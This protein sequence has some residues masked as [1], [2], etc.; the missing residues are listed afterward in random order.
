MSLNSTNNRLLRILFTDFA[1]V[2]VIVLAGCGSTPASLPEI[3]TGARQGEHAAFFRLGPTQACLHQCAPEAI[4]FARGAMGATSS[5]FH[6][7]H[8]FEEVL[9]ESTSLGKAVLIPVNELLHELASLPAC[10][11][12]LVHSSDHLWLVVGEVEIDGDAKVQLVHGKEQGVLASQQEILD[13]GFRGAWKLERGSEPISMRVGSGE[14]EMDAVVKNLGVVELGVPTTATFI[15]KNAGNSPLVLVNAGSS[16]SC[17]MATLT[18]QTELDIGESYELVVTLKSNNA[19]SQRQH[20]IL[21]IHNSQDHTVVSKKLGIFACQKQSLPVLPSVVDFGAVLPGSSSVR[22]LR[23]REVDSIRFSLKDVDVAELRLT[24]EISHD[25]DQRG[26]AT[27]KIS[28]ILT[29]DHFAVPGKY[30]GTCVIA[31]SSLTHPQARIPIQ[32][33]ILPTATIEP[34]SLAIGTVVI[35]EPRT[36]VLRIRSSL[37]ESFTVHVLKLPKQCVIRENRNGEIVELI[38][39]TKLNSPGVWHDEIGVEVMADS[40]THNLNIRCTGVAK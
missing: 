3:V 8:S 15:L 39:T 18:E 35:N 34:T 6:F 9:H 36:H 5:S 23:V 24:H 27:Y 29:P 21:E 10:S 37:S 11:A 4:E 19:V 13:G 17:T 25:V 1:I 33:E 2:M 22:L 12:V 26:F 30:A 28:L 31:T 20:V 7:D 32:Y 38:V 40:G 16:C 14:I